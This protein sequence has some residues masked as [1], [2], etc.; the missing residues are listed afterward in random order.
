[1][2][3]YCLDTSGISHPYEEQPEDIYESLWRFVREQIAAGTMAVT[4]EIF[5]EMI[6]IGSGLGEFIEQNKDAILYE[7]NQGDWNWQLY[8]QNATE[9]IA[10]HENHISEY[11]GGSAKT[12]CLNDISIIALA[13]TLSL[14][15]ISMESRLTLQEGSYKRRIPN[16][17][18]AEDIVHHTFNE[19][20]RLEQYEA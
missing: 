2:P 19:Y 11:T 6:L 13:K 7:V 14:P 12:V 10:R 16:I 17:C 1:M 18:D 3:K 15:V 9:M 8:V 20:L 4:K 5:D